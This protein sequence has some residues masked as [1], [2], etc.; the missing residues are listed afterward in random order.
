[1]RKNMKENFGKMIKKGRTKKMFSVERLAT[2]ANI[3]PEMVLAMESNSILY[4]TYTV[5]IVLKIAN[6]LEIDE[7]KIVDSMFIV[8]KKN[9][10]MIQELYE[11]YVYF[12]ELIKAINTSSNFAE[13][14]FKE[15]DI[16]M[17]LP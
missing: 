2:V 8:A 7:Q 3:S 10:D 4:D 12:G 13:T 1:M 6:I 17:N 11:K 15:L 16:F 5:Q 14:V 9:K